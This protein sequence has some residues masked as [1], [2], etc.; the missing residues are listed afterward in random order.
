MINKQFKFEDKI[1]KGY[2]FEKLK[3]K[4]GYFKAN[5]TLKIKVTRFFTCQRPLWLNSEGKILNNSKVTVFT[6][7]HTGDGWVVDIING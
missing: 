3:L 1:L 2:I 6:R 7:I 5:L 4:F